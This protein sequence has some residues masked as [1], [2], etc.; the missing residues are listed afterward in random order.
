MDGWMEWHIE[1]MPDKH[2]RVGGSSMTQCHSYAAVV[3]A[4]AIIWARADSQ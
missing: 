2:A 4:C 3:A 1:D